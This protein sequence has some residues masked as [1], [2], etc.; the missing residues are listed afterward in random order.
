MSSLIIEKFKNQL[1]ISEHCI[2]ID[3]STNY[4][5][6]KVNGKIVLIVG[7]KHLEWDS[8]IFNKK[9]GLFEIYYFDDEVSF[10]N[11][12]MEKVNNFC[13]KEKYECLFAKVSIENYNIMHLLESN[14][15]KL[16]DSIVT[17]KINLSNKVIDECNYRIR[18]LAESD[19]DN[20]LS[21]IDRLYSYGRFYADPNLN[22]K[23]VNELYKLWV[24]NEIKSSKVDVI[25]VECNNKLVGF[26]SCKYRYN[27]KAKKEEGII[28]LVGID[29]SCQGIGIGKQLLKSVLFYFKE[30]NI[31]E[32]YVG[33][34]I[35][36][37]SALNFYIASGFKIISSTNS[38]HKWI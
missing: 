31:D 3:E 17:L 36:N 7:I 21:I 14:G 16:M 2:N 11:L 26:I 13:V 6:I 33:T 1:I 24:T 23:D 29:K 18:V 20:V 15:Y 38:F 27:N 34:Q 19:I 8:N 25:G 12:T 28:S 37:I 35:D 30:K 10:I 22:N 32:V 9:I 5:L 4:F